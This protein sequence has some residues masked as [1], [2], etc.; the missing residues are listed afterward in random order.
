[1]E[2]LLRPV[3][4]P[5]DAGTVERRCETAGRVA[6]SIVPIAVLRLGLRLTNP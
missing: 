4:V 2:M 3:T 5:F 1:M 6:S